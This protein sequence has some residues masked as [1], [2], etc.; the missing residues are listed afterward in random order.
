M[1]GPL[2]GGFFWLT[3]YTT[4][5]NPG[6]S[7]PKERHQVPD[8]QKWQWLSR[9]MTFVPHLQPHDVWCAVRQNRQQPAWAMGVSWVCRKMRSLSLA[10]ARLTWPAS[11]RKPAFL[12]RGTVGV[13]LV[14]PVIIRAPARCWDSRIL[15]SAGWDHH[16]SRPAA[17]CGCS[18]LQ[19]FIVGLA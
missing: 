1:S 7:F 18:Q 11:G 3:L 2:R 10:A 9:A 19:N 8:I 6:R 15:W 5:P 16:H 17:P 4:E 13:D 12:R 14:H